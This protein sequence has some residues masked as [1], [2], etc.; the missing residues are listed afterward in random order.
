M[1]D[2]IFS[3]GSEF[4]AHSANF[5]SA[6]RHA[7]DLEEVAEVRVMHQ[8]CMPDCFVS[9][10]ATALTSANAIFILGV[11]SFVHAARND[12][13]IKVMLLVFVLSCLVLKRYM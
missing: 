6:G 13:F 7:L 5:A 9:S 11:S 4:S 10:A 3:F 12:V 2:T 1:H 8:N